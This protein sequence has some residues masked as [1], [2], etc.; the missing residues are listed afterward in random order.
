M[1]C[2]R[3]TINMEVE[4]EDTEVEAPLCFVS[5]FGGE[6]VIQLLLRNKSRESKSAKVTSWG[7]FGA[8]CVQR[9]CCTYAT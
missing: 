8:F 7:I 5:K 6:N 4:G 3:C 9:I 1:C 2:W